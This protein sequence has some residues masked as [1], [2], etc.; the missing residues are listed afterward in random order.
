M[1]RSYISGV[2]EEKNIVSKI[3]EKLFSII[4]QYKSLSI[5]FYPTIDNYV[6][7]TIALAAL[8]IG[9]VKVI[10]T[11]SIKPPIETQNPSILL[12]YTERINIKAPYYIHVEIGKHVVE[13]TGKGIHVGIYS[14]TPTFML[15]LL[16]PSTI[17]TDEML[18]YAIIVAANK[19]SSRGLD[20][21]LL[22]Q[23][24]EKEFIERYEAALRVFEWHNLPICDA[25]SL[26]IN[27]LIPGIS[28]RR[29]NC[30]AILGAK[31][32]KVIDEKGRHRKIPDLN[33]DELKK[34]VETLHRQM[35]AKL[36]TVDIGS[37][38]SRTYILLKRSPVNI[39]DTRF[40]YQL[41]AYIGEIEDAG[42]IIATVV[43]KLYVS[44]IR[45]LYNKTLR[46]VAIELENIIVN[47]KYSTG[48][49]SIVVESEVRL[50]PSM[51]GNILREFMAIEK[52]KPIIICSKGT[53]RCYTSIMELDAVGRKL[54]DT[55]NVELVGIRVEADS[56]DYLEEAIE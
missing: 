51:V 19:H 43:N 55:E 10:L 39:E 32:L 45:S 28:G 30:I 6:A 35:K 47:E 8:S 36:K 16:E 15:K 29:E 46:D 1:L 37:L 5:I 34:L 33:D 48:E 49:K 52:T 18:G 56:I 12:G 44:Y 53:S 22:A 24:Q 50:P 42:Y 13:D 11:P 25:L 2:E 21:E 40:A 54:I 4:S 17:I 41:L 23:A 38:V 3:S 31:G 7:A 26:T 14:S 27:P 20:H 9:D